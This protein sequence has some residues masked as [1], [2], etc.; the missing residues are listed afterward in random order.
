MPVTEKIHRSDVQSYSDKTSQMAS[1]QLGSSQRSALNRRL[2]SK[3]QGQN[4][5]DGQ[6]AEGVKVCW[7]EE[8][9]YPYHPDHQVELLHLQAEA[10]ALLIK[11]QTAGRKTNR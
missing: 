6:I 1:S 10:D 9:R 4:Q 3:A 7:I 11:L 5:T 2:Q 8:K